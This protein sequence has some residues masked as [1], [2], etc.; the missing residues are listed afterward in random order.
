M[1]LRD[2]TPIANSERLIFQASEDRRPTNL[3]KYSL[4]ILIKRLSTCTHTRQDE[5]CRR[6]EVAL[7]LRLLHK[8]L[9]EEH[10]SIG[11]PP[12]IARIIRTVHSLNSCCS[13]WIYMEALHGSNKAVSTR[14]CNYRKFI[15]IKRATFF[16]VV[17][18][19]E[20]RPFLRLLRAGTITSQSTWISCQHGVKGRIPVSCRDSS[21]TCK[22]RR[23][24]TDARHRF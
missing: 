8:V 10:Q 13:Q 11:A 18:L 14:P 24:E 5:T 2:S 22:Q 23:N 1:H 6:H 7:Y 3:S 19:L 21:D 15:S 12:N 16:S 20:A 4:G 9:P 17:R